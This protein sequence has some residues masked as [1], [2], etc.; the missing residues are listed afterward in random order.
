MV[1]VSPL[2]CK[3]ILIYSLVFFYCFNALG[4]TNL[5]AIID[6][7]FFSLTPA[8]NHKVVNGIAVGLTVH[9]WSAWNDTVY[10]ELN[11]L[12]LELGP[13]GIIGGLWGIMYGL[14]GVKDEH[15]NRT[16]LFLKHG[17]DSLYSNYPKYGTHVTG[18]SISLGGIS[19]TYNHGLF[20]NGLSG[21]CYTIEG[22]Q[23]SGLINKTAELKGVSI[24]AL[25]N[26]AT[27]GKG[28]QIG[29]INKCKTG[30]VLQ[31]GLFNR[32]GNQLVPFVNFRFRKDA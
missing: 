22:V 19:E 4:Q 2:F 18:V 23:V 20:V 12:N 9:P 31:F 25:A 28:V 24:A 29:L 10:M 13:M 11:G 6:T 32:I 3:I 26:V 15:G 27:K 8:T 14:A 21:G 5:P 16:G 7:S 30:N 17:Y 1:S